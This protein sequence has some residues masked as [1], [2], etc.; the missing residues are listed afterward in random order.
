MQEARLVACAALQVCAG[1]GEAIQLHAADSVGVLQSDVWT[2]QR[3]RRMCPQATALLA[4]TCTP[5]HTYVH[6]IGY[7]ASDV[8]LSSRTEGKMPDG[9]WKKLNCVVIL[10]FPKKGASLTFVGHN[11]AHRSH[12]SQGTTGCWAQQAVAG[13]WVQAGFATIAAPVP[14]W[15]GGYPVALL[16]HRHSAAIAVTQK[17]GIAACTHRAVRH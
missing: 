3:T 13:S 7:D 14:L 9:R 10:T 1:A 11:S 8:S 15:Q 5:T 16:V 2:P 17:D 12:R 4:H 6:P